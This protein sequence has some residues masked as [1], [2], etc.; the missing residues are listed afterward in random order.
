[1][2]NEYLQG[3][4]HHWLSEEKLR[5]QFTIDV[6]EKSYEIIIN[7]IRFKIR[8]DRVDRINRDKKL[9]IDYKTGKNCYV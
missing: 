3:L 2:Q 4:L 8:I 6:L 7:N 1:M 9:L 5:P